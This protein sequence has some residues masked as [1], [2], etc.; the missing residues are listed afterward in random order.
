MSN[1]KISKKTFDIFKNFASIR[2][3]IIVEPGNVIRTI[4]P[5]KNIMAE[6][7]VDEDFD[8]KFA[9]FD[10]GK[11]IATTTMF[12]NPDFGFKDK[13]VVIKSP[14]G[15]SVSYFYAD[16]KLVEKA[17]RTIKMPD[18]TVEFD[19][20]ASQIS[21]ILKASS[22]LQLDT[23]CIRPTDSGEIE[24]VS[25]DKKIGLNGSSNQFSLILKETTKKKFEIHID[26]DL[27]KMMN[28]DYHVEIG[29]TLVAKFTGKTDPLTYWIALRSES[30]IINK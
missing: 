11:F 19:L 10:L 17:D 5:A 25:F 23:I 9:I 22:V 12:A 26:I 20:A 24:I 18:I 7:R 21:E 28:G 13:Y 4:S 1:M 16:E 30:N 27:L 15:S 2:S 8:T 29:G 14:T 6:A 3:S